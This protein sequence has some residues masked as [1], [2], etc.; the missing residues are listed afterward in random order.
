MNKIQY[1]DSID[2]ILVSGKENNDNIWAELTYVYGNLVNNHK[3]MGGHFRIDW[4]NP[5]YGGK[6]SE[7]EIFDTVTISIE[8]LEN[9]LTTHSNIKK[10]SPEGTAAS[11]LTLNEC[12]A[13]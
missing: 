11:V 4:K 9:I 1:I 8:W 2:I 7:S 12:L 10:F 5:R 6:W 13:I 3:K